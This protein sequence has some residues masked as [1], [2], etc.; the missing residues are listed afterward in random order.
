MCKYVKILLERCV[1]KVNLPNKLT[2][3][4][5]VLVVVFALFAFPYP[6]VVE[7]LVDG[8]IFDIVRPYIALVIYIVASI[9][10]AVDG[11]IARRDNLITDFGKFLDPIADKLL[12]SAALLALCNVS[13]M[14]LW[15][16]LI[17]L[18]REFVVSGIRMLAASKGNVIAAGKLGKLKMIFQTIAIITLFVAGIVPTSLWSGFELIQSII[19]I[20]GNVIMVA[21]VVLTIVSGVEYVYKNRELLK[22]KKD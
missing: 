15:A 18:A 2:I 7:E 14:Y 19:Y 6:A 10:D 13:I 8:T 20:L 22:V 3:T 4:R 1:L 17:I 16:T 9:T 21:A 5:L 12:V 11:H